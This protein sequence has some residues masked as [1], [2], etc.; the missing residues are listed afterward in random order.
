MT[1]QQ[2]EPLVPFEIPM[3]SRN[4]ENRWSAFPANRWAAGFATAEDAVRAAELVQ[5]ADAEFARLG[6]KRTVWRTYRQV[7]ELSLEGGLS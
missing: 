4:G 6:H 5:E 7:Y 3:R 2:P 1:N